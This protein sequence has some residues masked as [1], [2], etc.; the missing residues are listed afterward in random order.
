[1]YNIDIGKCIKCD[2]CKIFCPSL[3]KSIEIHITT[4]NYSIN[5]ATCINCGLCKDT[6]PVLAI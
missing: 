6:C 4:G 5:Q 2:V 1:M 3:P